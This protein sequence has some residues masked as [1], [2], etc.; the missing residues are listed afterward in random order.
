MTPSVETTALAPKGDWRVL[1]RSLHE[2]RTV[3]SAMSDPQYRQR[4]VG[5]IDSSIGGH[6]RHCLDH[7]RALL[8]GVETG[9]INYDQRDRGTPIE[10]DR[11]A[12]L[13]AINDLSRRLDQFDAA[14]LDRPIRVTLMLDDGVTVVDAASSAAREAAFVLSH[15]IHHNALL[16]AM[17]KTLGVRAPERFGYAPSTIAHL[18]QAACALSPSSA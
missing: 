13:H 12:A 15:T 5:A 8:R 16:A 11:R 18:E 1:G 7:F 3:L 17:F 6:V 2:L 4:P 9:R 10:T 14:L